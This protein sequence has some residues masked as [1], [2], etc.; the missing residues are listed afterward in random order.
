MA[1]FCLFDMGWGETDCPPAPTLLSVL[2]AG[3]PSLGQNFPGRP[4]RFNAG[5]VRNEQTPE[6]CSFLRT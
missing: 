3:L 1:L 4:H 6:L 2:A 5:L